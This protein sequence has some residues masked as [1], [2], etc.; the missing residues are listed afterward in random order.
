M[1]IRE[2]AVGDEPHLAEVFR[3]A[4][5]QTAAADYTPEQ[6][7]AWAP[8]P[9]DPDL[10]AK[11]MQGINPFVAELDGVI[12]G[13]ADVQ[14]DG[15]VDHFFVSPAAG[16]RGVGSA[17]MHRIHEAARV[18]R[19]SRLYSEVSLTARPFFEKFDFVVDEAQVVMVRGI[20][21]ENFRMSKSL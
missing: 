18:K 12:V 7:A 10:W 21:L 2:F 5:H 4:I 15:H 3:Q 9:H 11:R 14:S 19:L 16:R 1:L 20:P 6:L 17:L 8:A 13:Y